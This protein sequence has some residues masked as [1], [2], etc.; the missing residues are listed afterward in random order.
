MTAFTKTITDSISLAGCTP[1]TLWDDATFSKWDT[2]FWDDG[3]RD[4]VQTIGKLISESLSSADTLVKSTTKTI[5]ES[6]S[7]TDTFI[8]AFFRTITETQSIDSSFGPEY[9]LDATLVWNYDFAA[10]TP[11]FESMATATF[12]Q[13]SNNSVTWTNVVTNVVGWT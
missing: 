11:N 1:S 12:T 9:K 2:A 6:E 5:S 3:T 8:M 4:I 7:I 13:Q 10:F